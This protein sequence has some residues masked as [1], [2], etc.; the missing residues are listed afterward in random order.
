M[1]LDLWP[2]QELEAFCV[3]VTRKVPWNGMNRDSYRLIFAKFI[4]ACVVRIEAIEQVIYLEVNWKHYTSFLEIIF[5][6]KNGNGR[7]NVLSI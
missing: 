3:F 7:R 6:L 5:R 1:V 4:D 2:H